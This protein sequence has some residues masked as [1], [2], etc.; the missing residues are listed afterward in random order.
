MIMSD[1]TLRQQLIDLQQVII[2][3]REYAKALD[4]ENLARIGEIKSRMLTVLDTIGEFPEDEETH[5]L[6]ATVKEENRRNAYL[7]YMT[8]QWVRNLM[9]FYGQ[10]TVPNTYGAQGNDVRLQHGGR[11][12]SGRI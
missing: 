3:E 4:M 6:A 2:Q 7:F 11:L 9:T 5:R 1:S 10:R 8:L 12:L